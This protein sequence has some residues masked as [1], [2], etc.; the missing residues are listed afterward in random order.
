MSD[1]I[2]VDL[3]ARL[4][5]RFQLQHAVVVDTPSDDPADAATAPGTGRR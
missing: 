3:S 1:G 2:D 4:Q 5:E